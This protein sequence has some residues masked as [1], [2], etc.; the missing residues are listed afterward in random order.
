MGI[1]FSSCTNHSEAND[2]HREHLIEKN[3]EKNIYKN[4]CAN[5]D[6][7]YMVKLILCGPSE[8]GK[9][10]FRYTI[11]DREMH[12]YEPTMGV[13]FSSSIFSFPHIHEKYK[14]QIWDL[15]GS[16]R[17]HSVTQAYY[18]GSSLILFIYKNEDNIEQFNSTYKNAGRQCGE[19]QDKIIFI[20]NKPGQYL[21]Q[22]R[23]MEI[24]G[25]E[26]QQFMMDV[27]NKQNIN[28]L[29]ETII[30][31]CNHINHISNHISDHMP[32]KKINLKD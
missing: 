27:K 8:S 7:N 5:C 28:K 13:D 18:K 14:I 10:L 1:K 21:E 4:K 16:E 22:I 9:S 25:Y 6:Y 11:E 23:N 2:D 30:P 17:F 19:D 24:N 20:F 26:Y 12:K 15:G 3:I 31:S 29:F 32:S